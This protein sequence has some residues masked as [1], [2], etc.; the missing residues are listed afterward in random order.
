MCAIATQNKR[1]ERLTNE[2]VQAVLGSASAALQKVASLRAHSSSSSSRDRDRAAAASNAAS[3]EGTCAPRRSSGPAPGAICWMG[4]SFVAYGGD[5]GGSGGEERVGGEREADEDLEAREALDFDFPDDD[6][7]SRFGSDG[8]VARGAAP[9]PALA[10]ECTS[11]P[12]LLEL[13]KNLQSLAS[14]V[15]L[16]HAKRVLAAKA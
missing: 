6:S 4:G 15:E 9:Q 7:S 3:D 5:G 11:R 12:A 1:R 8:P 14:V 16:E 10:S 13:I 2:S